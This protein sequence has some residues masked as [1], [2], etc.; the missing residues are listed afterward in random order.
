MGAKLTSAA[1][2]GDPNGGGEQERRETEGNG[3]R[4]HG[5]NLA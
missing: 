5:L 3:R 4:S 2:L 1:K